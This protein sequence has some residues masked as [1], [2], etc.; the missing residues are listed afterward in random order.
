MEMIKMEQ[1]D[2][3][4]QAIK[5]AEKD[6][7]PYIGIKD[8]ELHVLGDPNKT[9]IKAADYVVH[10]GFPNTPEYKAK[11]QMHG[12]EMGRETPDGRYFESIRKFTNVYLTPRRMAG[13]I[14]AM[15]QLE[16]FLLK[17]TDNGEIR[18]MNDDEMR[19]ILTGLYNELSDAVYDVVATVLSIPYDEVDFMLPMNAVQNAVKI[20]INNASAV[21]ETDLFFG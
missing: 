18:E 4:K 9:E 15:A 16:A 14:S 6:D 13:V 3:L 19:M 11:A 2:E 10:F 17:V 12:D 1:L 8:E 20:Y 7:T 5:E 21:N